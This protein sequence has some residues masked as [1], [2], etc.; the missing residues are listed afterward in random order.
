MELPI[1]EKYLESDPDRKYAIGDPIYEM[2]T[3][4]K[5]GPKVLIL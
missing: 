2:Y 4:Y 5:Q 3:A 1:P